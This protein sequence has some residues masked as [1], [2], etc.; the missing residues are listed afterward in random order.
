MQTEDSTF[1][2]EVNGWKTFCHR[3]GEGND[4]SIIFLHGS[5]PGVSA[6]SNWMFAL[7]GLGGKYDCIAPDLFGFA[8]SEHPE[9]PPQ[10]TLAWMDVW[11]GQVIGLMDELGVEKTHLVGNSMGGSISLHLVDRH[12]E[13]F[14]RVVL[15]GT[16]GAPDA[17]TDGLRAGWG[18]YDD[19]SK[20]ALAERVAAF[21]YDVESI[22]GDIGAIAEA[23][24]EA[25]M[26]DD[27]KRS[28]TA[29]FGGD[30]EK[31]TND[32]ALPEETL[33]GLD[34]RFLLAHGREDNY[35]RMRDSVWLAERIPEADLHI[36]PKCGHWIQIEKRGPFNHLV[37]EFLASALD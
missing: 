11:V 34:H 25:V 17:L 37:G 4:E 1:T 12:P 27:I 13:R 15:M 21:V 26:R 20:E 5:G 28:F 7:P 6:Y 31:H 18:F 32:L 30:L 35:V 14:E 3:E 9:D 33:N 8:G 24:W 22:G 2:I 16:V 10:G 36:F 23:R 29:M 19:P